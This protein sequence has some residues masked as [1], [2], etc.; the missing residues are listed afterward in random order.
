MPRREFLRTSDPEW[1][2]LGRRGSA[3]FL[4]VG[5]TLIVV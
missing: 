3:V 4:A 2:R 5:C 1:L